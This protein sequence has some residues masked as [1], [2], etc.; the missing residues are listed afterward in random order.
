MELHLFPGYLNEEREKEMFAL[1]SL[2]L[3]KYSISAL[4]LLVCVVSGYIAHERAVS[5]A[6]ER[7]RSEVKQ[8]YT[9]TY[10]EGLEE[11]LKA[12]NSLNEE[13]KESYAKLRKD[14]DRI[15][16]VRDSDIKLLQQRPTRAEVESIRSN[17]NNTSCPAALSAAELPRED[18][19]FLTREAARAEGVMEERDFYYEQYETVRRKMESYQRSI[20]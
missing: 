18:A 4:I 12:S 5:K 8:Q 17:T 6:L 19:E 9:Q 7:A 16:A 13:L 14:K 3:N 10:V 2:L 15:I 1:K 20:N 11:A